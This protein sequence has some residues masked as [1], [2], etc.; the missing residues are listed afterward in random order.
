MR[1]NQQVGKHPKTRRGQRRAT[2]MV[3]VIRM[4]NQEKKRK[5]KALLVK[6]HL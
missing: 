2:K 1:K 3:K 6:N 4:R 5:K